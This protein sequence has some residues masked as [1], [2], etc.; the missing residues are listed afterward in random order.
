MAKQAVNRDAEVERYLDRLGVTYELRTNLSPKQFDL[1]ESLRNQAR[2]RGVLV[3]ETVKRYTEA[4][5]QGDIFPP[6]VAWE[7]EKKKL[8]ILDGNHRLMAH[9]EAGR[10]LDAYVVGSDT[11]P[12]TRVL[13][14]FKANVKHGL[15]SSDEDRLHHALFIHDTGVTLSDAAREFGVPVAVLRKAAGQAKA[16]RRAD[17]AGVLRTHW[18]AISAAAR[19]RLD[20]I[21]TDEGFKAAAEL[22]AEAG[23]G[24]EDVMDLVRTL[25]QSRS[26]SRQTAQIAAQRKLLGERIQEVATSGRNRR[27]R[28]GRRQGPQARLGLALGHVNALPQPQ[29]FSDIPKD[30]RKDLVKRIDE[31]SGRLQ[32]VRDV[33]VR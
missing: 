25:N 13:I 30:V 11:P 8:I 19:G 12:M 22:V 7:N 10:V 1:E 27:G 31:A 14:T 17:E 4:A 28:R 24:I 29:L 6:V 2:V 9:L 15:P 33:L 23:L 32:A 18:D 5:H 26:G 20:T 16:D 21:T 3:E